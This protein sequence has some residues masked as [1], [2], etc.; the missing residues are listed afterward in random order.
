MYGYYFYLIFLVNFSVSCIEDYSQCGG[1]LWNGMTNCCANSTC[2]YINQ[3]YS[4]CSPSL[5]SPST[6]FE[7]DSLPTTT[8]IDDYVSHVKATTSIFWNCCVTS[9]ALA[10]SAYTTTASKSC[11]SAIFAQSNANIYPDCSYGSIYICTDQQ[12]WNVSDTLSYGYADVNI[13]VSVFHQQ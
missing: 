9:C 12:P 2:V 10:Y 13:I 5:S 7:T 3:S 8:T 11:Q 6:A 1:H 4:Q